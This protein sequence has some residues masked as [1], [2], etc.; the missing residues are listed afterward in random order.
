MLM[1]SQLQQMPV[2]SDDYLRLPFN[3]AL[4]NAVIRIVGERGY[5]LTGFEDFG[6]GGYMAAGIRDMLIVPVELLAELSGQF[7]QNRNGRDELHFAFHCPEIRCLSPASRRD[8]SR[9]IDIRIK[10]D[11]SHYRPLKTRRSISASVIS[12]SFAFAEPYT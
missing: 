3:C 11:P 4:K 1:L 6:E 10:D 7:C 2:T 12:I 8:K 9:D 5:A